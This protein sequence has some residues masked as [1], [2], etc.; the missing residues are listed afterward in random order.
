MFK[1]LKSQHVDFSS[2]FTINCWE[3]MGN[4]KI[5]KIKKHWENNA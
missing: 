1:L 5:N 3:K 2:I 4:K